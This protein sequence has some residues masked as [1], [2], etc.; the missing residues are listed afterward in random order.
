MEHLKIDRHRGGDFGV[1]IYG[2]GVKRFTISYAKNYTIAGAIAHYKKEYNIF[3][4]NFI[5]QYI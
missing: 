3:T 2:D 5:V 4:N 1:T